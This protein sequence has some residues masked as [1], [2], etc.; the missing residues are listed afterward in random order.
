[1]KRFKLSF[2]L[3]VL[4]SVTGNTVSAYDFSA[5][6]DDGVTIYYFTLGSNE[7]YVTYGDNI[8]NSYSGVVRIPATVT[9]NNVTRTVSSINS[10]FYNCSGLTSVEIPNSVRSISIGAFE[11]CTG[12][13][14]IEIPSSVISIGS[15][16]FNNCSN[17]TSITVESGNTVYDSRNNCNAIIETSSNTLIRGC[18]NTV[19]P[20]SVTSIGSS[21]FEGCTSL[22]FIEIPNGVTSIGKNAFADCTGLTSIEIPSSVTTIPVFNVSFYN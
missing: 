18:Q 10:A 19:I 7:A 6:N 1:M 14:S 5:M 22:T 3:F 13:T 12:L 2:L 9:Y 20:N 15:Q 8:D 11:G 16:A 4:M 21:A 17:L